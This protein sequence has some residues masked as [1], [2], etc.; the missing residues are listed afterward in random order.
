MTCDVCVVPHPQRAGWSMGGQQLLRIDGRSTGPYDCA[1][2]YA[3]AGCERG[4]A[5]APVVPGEL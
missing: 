4:A 1:A 5:N 2:F 3:G